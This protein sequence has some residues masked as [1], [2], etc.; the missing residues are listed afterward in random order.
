VHDAAGQPAALDDDALE[1]DFAVVPDG[2]DDGVRHQPLKVVFLIRLIVN[3]ET[4][5]ATEFLIRKVWRTGGH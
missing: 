2:Q 3:H 1:E 5:A 4:D